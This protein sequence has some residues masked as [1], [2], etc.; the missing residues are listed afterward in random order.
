MSNLVAIAYEDEATAK[1]V[2]S[3]LARTSLSNEQ[4]ADL[5]SALDR[6]GAPA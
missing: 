3:G 2:M 6:R 4:E 1:E 5:Q